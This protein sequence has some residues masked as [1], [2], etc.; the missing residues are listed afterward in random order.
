MIIEVQLILS[1]NTEENIKYLNFYFVGILL[2]VYETK[3]TYRY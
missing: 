3:L 1:S 2:L